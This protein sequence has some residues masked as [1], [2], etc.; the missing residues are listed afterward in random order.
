MCGRYASARKRHELLEEFDIPRDA[1]EARELAADYNVAPTKE[2]Y[3]VL[4]RAPREE[5]GTPPAE[6]AA[7]VRQLRVVR[8]GLVPSWAKDPSIG[9]RMINARV[10]TVAEKP[11]FRRAFARRRCLLPADGYYEWYAQEGE[12]KKQPYFIR[13]ADGGVLAMAGIYEF[14]RDRT[15]PDDDPLAWWTTVTVITTDALDELG[16]IHDRMPMFVPHWDWSAWLDPSL[17]EAEAALGLLRPAAETGL[18]AYPVSTDVN[19]VRNNGP[20]LVKP[21]PEEG[22]SGEYAPTLF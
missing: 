8:W 16:R 19:N 10:E 7:P 4:T 18:I 2:V 6:E 15:R 21:L 22:I 11:A 5:D 14:W 12:K 9:S 17:G 13:P 20:E 3:A 1:P